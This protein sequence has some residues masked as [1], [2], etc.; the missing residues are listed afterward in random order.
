MIK[1]FM[2]FTMVVICIMNMN[3]LYPWIAMPQMD[4][5]ALPHC[6]KL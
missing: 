6:I 1:L 2:L 5:F 3:Q 4:C